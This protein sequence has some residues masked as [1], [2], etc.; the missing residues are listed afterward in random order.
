MGSSARGGR[1]VDSDGCSPPSR[2]RSDPGGSWPTV[3]GPGWWHVV[4]HELPQ[5]V[6]DHH[7]LGTRAARRWTL[8]SIPTRT[9]A[10]WPQQLRRCVHGYRVAER[11]EL[12]PAWRSADADGAE[13]VG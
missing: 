6:N 10:R 3:A 1:R 7:E 11:G 9:M 8:Q 5:R 13:S 4:P 12:F 2:V